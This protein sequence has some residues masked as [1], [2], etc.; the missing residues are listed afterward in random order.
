MFNQTIGEQVEEVMVYIIQR[1]P[2]NDVSYSILE[3]VSG[4]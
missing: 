2:E 1:C 3:F 4:P